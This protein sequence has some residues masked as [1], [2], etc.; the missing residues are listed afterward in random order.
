[1]KIGFTLNNYGPAAHPGAITAVARR[2]EE[3][4]YASLW[5][6]DRLL[7]PVE[8]R[9]PYPAVADGIL[10]EVFK[11]S[12]DPVLVLNWAAACTSKI[13]LGTG[14]LQMPFY[15]AALLA[16][17]LT[18]LDILSQGRLIAGF[19]Q[20]WSDDEFEA[21][22]VDPRQRASRADDLLRALDALWT[23]EPAV[24]KGQRFSVPPSYIAR[25][26]QRPRPKI[27][28]AAFTPPALARIGKFADGWLPVG[29]PTQGLAQM[30]PIVL[31]GAREAGRDPAQLELCVGLPVNPS[32]LERESLGQQLRDLRDL[33]AH[34][35]YFMV[36]SL[37][38]DGADVLAAL[39]QLWEVAQQALA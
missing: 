30:W 3:L 16:R 39:E 14:I 32:A 5:V 35:A 27:L 19:G 1:M 24:Y 10:P 26:V 17:S 36:T 13:L 15:N 6:A 38:S 9:N 22:G 4:G 34:H 29:I 12:L 25:P 11:H 7:Y 8:P 21:V 37:Q 31:A 23:Q 33:G 28:L 20:G 2:A 18:T